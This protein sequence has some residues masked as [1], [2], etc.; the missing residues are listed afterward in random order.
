M[1][2][3]CPALVRA[4]QYRRGDKRHVKRDPEV[5]WGFLPRHKR[6]ISLLQGDG[7]RSTPP[8]H[9][10]RHAPWLCIDL[11]CAV[12]CP[13]S[14]VQDSR[15]AD[16]RPGHTCGRA[17]MRQSSR[18]S[19]DNSC[20]RPGLELPSSL[21]NSRKWSLNGNV[22]HLSSFSIL[23]ELLVKNNAWSMSCLS[24]RAAPWCF[25]GVVIML[26]NQ[27]SHS[28]AAEASPAGG[29]SNKVAGSLSVHAGGTFHTCAFLSS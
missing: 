22:V 13:Y 6:A 11:S 1:W 14:R 17:G 19:K 4:W 28:W 27:G 8:T 9:F 15:A 16:P 2:T 21:E 26:R 24:S 12:S 25:P 7:K 3:S 20:L 10:P 23:S 29:I 18:A 5:T